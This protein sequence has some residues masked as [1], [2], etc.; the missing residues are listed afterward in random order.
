M[1]IGPRKTGRSPRVL[2]LTG[3]PGWA[4]SV[5][6]SSFVGPRPVLVACGLDTSGLSGGQTRSGLDA[7][8]LH[9]L[10]LRRAEAG[11]IAMRRLTSIIAILTAAGWLAAAAAAAEPTV[12]L[13]LDHGGFRAFLSWRTPS[14][15]TA[16]GRPRPLREPKRRNLKDE[17]RK[18]VRVVASAPPPADWTGLEFEDAR[19][20]RARGPVAV[21][22]W[23][24]GDIYT[25]GNPAEWSRVCVRAKFRVTDPKRVTAL[26]LRAAYHGGVVVYVNGKELCRQHLPAGELGPAAPAEPYPDEAYIRPDGKRYGEGDE[27]KFKDRLACRLRNL[28]AEGDDAGVAIPASMLRKGVN[29]IALAA[30]AARLRALAVDAPMGKASWRGKLTPWPHAGVVAVRLTAGTGAGLVPGVGP[31]DAV[32][33]WN[34]Q[35]FESVSVWDQADPC[36]T[37]RPIRIV[38]A[39]NGVFSGKVVLSSKASIRGLSATATGLSRGDSRGKIPASAVTV[40]LAEPARPA[41]SWNRPHRFDRLLAKFPAEVPPVQITLRRQKVQPAAAAVAPVWVTVRVPA[42]APAGMYRGTLSVRARDAAE[43]TFT[44][45]IELKV[46][47][48]KVPDAKH[49]VTH[50]NL[51]QSPDTVARYYKVPLWSDRHFELMGRSLEALTKVANKICVVNLVAEAANLGNAESMVRWVKGP[52]GAIT[53]DFSVLDRYL[54]LYAAKAGK[55]GI[56]CL[57][58]WGHYRKLDKR[59]SPPL[60]VSLSDPAGGKV[61][62][63]PQPP[64][65]TAENEAFWRPVFAAMK[66]RLDRRGWYDVAAVCHTSYC[67]APTQEM[68]G[69]FQSLWPDGKWMNVSHSNPSSYKAVKGSMPVPYSEWV[70]GCGGLYNPDGGRI[71]AFPRAWKLGTKR[72]EL[73]NPRVG[74]GFIGVFRDY[75]TLSAYRTITEAAMQG[76][77]RGLGRVGG[78][79]WPLPIG[80]R[81]KYEPLCDSRFAVG[82]VNNTMALTSPGPDGATFNERL[83]MFREGVQLAEAIICVQRA[84]DA[85]RLDEVQARRTRDL[86]DE[87]ARYY[88]RTRPGQPAN[89]WSFESSPW[90]DRDA[91]L[92][93]LAAQ[94]ARAAKPK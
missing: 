55:P 35:P 54:D 20:P 15:V 51:Y 19:W 66:K 34:C 57:N 1:P 68:V 8:V 39:Q 44:V 11:I 59:H 47:D 93:A 63:M 65:G 13:N 27:K 50:H 90:Q 78:D 91:R 21:R 30:R 48:W 37:L 56:L 88:L 94:A 32:Q 45:P 85:G 49:F 81:G 86:L 61:T 72:I 31:V 62:T 58:V 5:T 6:G 83:E 43:A 18:P 25:P 41:V 9:A 22:E 52:N 75:S 71:K 84:L 64:Y 33:A 3:S 16:D 29:V 42:D 46:H 69:V 24:G 60:N 77:L 76:G 26:R 87:R 10:R 28:S 14:L 17:D 2:P 7:A 92:F 67:W 80:R 53:Y 70:W 89:W 73:G 36:E 82:P 74:V 12:V 79:Y 4:H 40:R 38:G 23:L